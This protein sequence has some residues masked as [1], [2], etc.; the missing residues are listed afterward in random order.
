MN[1]TQIENAVESAASKFESYYLDYFN[2]FL[3]VGGFADY[4]GISDEEA[5]RRISIGRKIHHK[6]K[7]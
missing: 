4:Y 7:G 5:E 1:M 2:N 3:T 6:R